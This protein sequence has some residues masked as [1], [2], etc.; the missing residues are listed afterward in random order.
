MIKPIYLSVLKL[1]LVSAILMVVSCSPEYLPNTINTPLFEDKGEI[2][3]NVGQ[4]ISGTDAQLAYA[5][6]DHIGVMAN[7]SFR[8]QTSDTTDNYHKHNFF[9]FGAGYYSSVSDN[10]VFSIYGG[11][12]LGAVKSYTE[13]NLI[14]NNTTDAD[15]SRIF[16]QPSFGVST[17]YFDASIASR[18][19]L[20][21]VD[22]NDE[23][24]N[25]SSGYQ[26]VVEPVI[27]TRFGFKNV[28]FVSQAGLAIPFN[29]N[30]LD[31]DIQPFIF[32]VG[33]HFNLDLIG[34]KS[35]S[36]KSSFEY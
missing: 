15:L 7:T 6:T 14:D 32:S 13:N 5:V 17:N 26:P 1:F 25:E 31:F 11:Y 35:K 24:L 19:V 22:Y 4:G 10:T 20:I 33:L 18:L 29:N 9:E 34:D 30:K 21:D 27:T 2:Q 16:I 12:G 28:K 8:S 3:A 23:I 36:D